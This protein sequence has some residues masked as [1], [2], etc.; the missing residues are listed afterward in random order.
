MPV[1][2]NQTFYEVQETRFMKY[3]RPGLLMLFVHSTGSWQK[4]NKYCLFLFFFRGV[5][6][7]P[8]LNR[9]DGIHPNAKGHKIVAGNVWAV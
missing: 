8:E 4:K 5:G 1:I 2:L 6:G 9:A 3:R 7:E